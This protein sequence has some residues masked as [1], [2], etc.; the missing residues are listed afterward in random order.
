MENIALIAIY[1]FILI[2]HCAGAICSFIVVLDKDINEIKSFLMAES[3]CTAIPFVISDILIIYSLLY[4]HEGSNGK[5]FDNVIQLLESYGI[6]MFVSIF[7]TITQTKTSLLLRGIAT[8]YYIYLRIFLHSKFCLPSLF[9]FVG[10]AVTM[11][12]DNRNIR[13]SMQSIVAIYACSASFFNLIYLI[14]GKYKVGRLNLGTKKSIV[15]VPKLGRPEEYNKANR[16]LTD[17]EIA[18]LEVNGTFYGGSAAN[19]LGFLSSLIL[20]LI[21]NDGSAHSG[22]IVLTSSKITIGI[23]LQIIPIAHFKAKAHRSLNSSSSSYRT[24]E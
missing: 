14:L 11:I 8:K 18:F 9:F 16:Q 15:S 6:F 1:S 13:V 2:F 23:G 21:F 20:L 3:L 12:Y 17:L 19:F 10:V 4:P 7:V 5:N 24:S 22:Y